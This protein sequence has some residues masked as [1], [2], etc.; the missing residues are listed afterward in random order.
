MSNPAN[1]AR[2]SHLLSPT[3]T[4]IYILLAILQNFLAGGLFFGWASLSSTLFTSPNGCNLT[5]S[6]V[7]T[8]F[9]CGSFTNFMSP[10]LLGVLLD[11][12][13]PRIT[14][15]I[16]LFIVALGLLGFSLSSSF[17]GFLTATLCIS[18]GGPGVQNSLIHLGNVR[19]EKRSLLTSFITGAF[20]LSFVVYAGFEK[21]WEAGYNYETIFGAYG[22]VIFGTSLLSLAVWPDTSYDSKGRLTKP[23]V[24]EKATPSE[25][26]PLTSSS[27]ISHYTTSHTS[28][29]SHPPR[30][31]PSPPPTTLRGVGQNHSFQPS[32]A[33]LNSYLRPNPKGQMSTH[34]SFVLSTVAFATGQLDNLNV[35]D[36]P[37]AYQVKSLSYFRIVLF[38]ALLS[39]V[40]NFGVGSVG[41]MLSD[42]KADNLSTLTTE[43]SVISGLG[44]LGMPIVGWL[45]DKQ[46]EAF[47]AVVTSCLGICYCVLFLN[48]MFITSFWFYSMFRSFLFCYFFANLPVVMG[49]KYFGILAGIAFAASG[50]GACGL[51]A[52]LPIWEKL[53]QKKKAKEL[54]D[55]FGTPKTLRRDF[56]RLSPTRE[57]VGEE[58]DDSDVL[59]F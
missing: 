1:P 13:G 55:V 49:F 42:F 31:S 37:F 39:Y 20:S 7:S 5:P 56:H 52:M 57:R 38:F 24:K 33:P 8:I 9:S 15:F 14:S 27:Q 10:L 11:T 21:I 4:T 32:K 23:V 19:P 58:E 35:K 12:S 22:L 3:K 16:S 36:Q 17:V 28:H 26:T 40:A 41:L 25:K 51:A 2:K 6:Q 43:F 45:L 34:P 44:V 47:T 54:E 53:E 50:A 30:R 18:F 59:G 29:T 48:E 46:G